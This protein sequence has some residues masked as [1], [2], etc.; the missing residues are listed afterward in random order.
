MS[1][2]AGR[3]SSPSSAPCRL[4]EHNRGAARQQVAECDGLRAVVLPVASRP[5]QMRRPTHR[6][7]AGVG[8][9]SPAAWRGPIIMI[10]AAATRSPRLR[11]ATC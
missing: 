9:A 8:L 6:Q 1:A 7:V 2:F 3:S 5:L 4:A 11:L 10:Y